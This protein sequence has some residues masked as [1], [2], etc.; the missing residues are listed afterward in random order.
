[1]DSAGNEKN[2]DGH[3]KGISRCRHTED[4]DVEA[5]QMLMKRLEI[6]AHLSSK[7]Y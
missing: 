2:A 4:R 6:E 7:R 1:M 5:L 3:L